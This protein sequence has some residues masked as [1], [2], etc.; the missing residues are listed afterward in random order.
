ME[1][2]VI[3]KLKTNVRKLIIQIA[4]LKRKVENESEDNS[5]AELNKNV[6]NERIK[7]KGENFLEPIKAKNTE[8]RKTISKQGNNICTFRYKVLRFQLINYKNIKRNIEKE[9]INY[10]RINNN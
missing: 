6:Q 10:K 8:S 5:H 3:S 2:T 9:K 4:I 1:I 7:V